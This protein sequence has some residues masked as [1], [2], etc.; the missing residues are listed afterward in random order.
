MGPSN[1]VLAERS[2][3]RRYWFVYLFAIVA[4]G[5]VG[6]LFVNKVTTSNADSTARDSAVATRSVEVSQ[7]TAGGITVYDK[8]TKPYQWSDGNHTID[9]T[10]RIGSCD[11]N[12]YF[13]S[14]D[15]PNK[16]A[17]I[18]PL[19]LTIPGDNVHAPG[20][21]VEITE[22]SLAQVYATLQDSGLRHCIADDKRFVLN[23]NH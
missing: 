8:S 9:V 13:S 5:A 2:H 14:P 12:G 16:P 17:D 22:G 4:F 23:Y 21:N 11:V 3:L 6:W 10:V 15:R 1:R 7:L 19:R 18:S 20:A